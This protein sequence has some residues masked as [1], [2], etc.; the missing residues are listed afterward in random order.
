MIANRTV[1]V[2]SFVA[3]LSSNLNKPVSFIGE[4]VL[5]KVIMMS[6]PK[7]SIFKRFAPKKVISIYSL[8]RT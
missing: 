5:L 2:P 6:L 4:K 8:Y 1:I 3:V 7:E